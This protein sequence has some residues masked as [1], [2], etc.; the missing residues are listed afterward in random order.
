[1][2]TTEALDLA[3]WS[4]RDVLTLVAGPDPTERDTWATALGAELVVPVP[5]LDV[6]ID[7]A[8]RRP[9]PADTIHAIHEWLAM[10]H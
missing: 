10:Q 3:C 6:L 1:M 4:A 7:R 9:D 5:P 8:R 2:D